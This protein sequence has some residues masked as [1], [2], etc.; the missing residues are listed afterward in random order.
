MNKNDLKNRKQNRLDS[1]HYD[2]GYFFVTINT[3]DHQKVFGEVLGDEMILNE[4]GKIVKEYWININKVYSN[5]SIGN[6]II[7]PNHMHGIIIID[8]VGELIKLPSNKNGKI[9]SSPT[10]KL[11]NII[12]GFKQ[13]S[14]KVIREMGLKTFQRQRSF[15]DHIIRN[16]NDMNR[17]VEYIQINPYKRENDEYYR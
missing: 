11:S 1:F 15:Y 13:S 8:N 9:I 3:K 12:K 17:V 5:V 10:N 16:E 6:F 14:G 4:Y 7:M 2:S